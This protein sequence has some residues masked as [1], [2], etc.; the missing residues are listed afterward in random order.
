MTIPFHHSG[1][2]FLI[3][4]LNTIHYQPSFGVPSCLLSIHLLAVLQRSTLLSRALSL[5]LRRLELLHKF[6]QLRKLLL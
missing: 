2:Q 6:L 5:P 4:A 1:L 3:F